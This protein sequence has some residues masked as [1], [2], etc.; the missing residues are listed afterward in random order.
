MTLIT[1][2]LF[3][4]SKAGEW[5][6]GDN[7]P[8]MSQRYPEFFTRPYHLQIVGNQEARIENIALY[9]DDGHEFFTHSVIELGKIAK[10]RV[11]SIQGTKEDLTTWLEQLDALEQAYGLARVEASP[12]ITE[13][14]DRVAAHLYTARRITD[15]PQDKI[16]GKL[17]PIN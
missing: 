12:L 16:L 1:Y 4:A 6:V 13:K 14:M 9:R 10:G 5:K 7:V 8:D 15:I 2:R 17:V 3:S 11:L